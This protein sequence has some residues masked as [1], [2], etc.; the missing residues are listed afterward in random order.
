MVIPALSY[1][2]RSRLALMAEIAC[3]GHVS[4]SDGGCETNG[5]R[6]LRCFALRD[7]PACRD[8]VTLATVYVRGMAHLLC[9]S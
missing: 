1:S 9:V 6:I 3:S 7:N 5:P 4:L 8:Q 2:L